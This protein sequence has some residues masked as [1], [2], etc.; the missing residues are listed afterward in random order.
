MTAPVQ[1]GPSPVGGGPV[2]SMPH[3]GLY[4]RALEAEPRTYVTARERQTLALAANG[5]TNRAIAQAL[6]LG[7]ETVK[8]RMQVLRRKLRAHDRAHAVAV[9][10]ALGLLSLSEVQVSPDANR[11]YRSAGDRRSVTKLP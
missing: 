4:P 1:V 8:S 7:E 2:P 3:K 9:G 5:M 11:G 6:G 10:L